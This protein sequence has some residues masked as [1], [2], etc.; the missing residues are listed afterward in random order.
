M[1]TIEVNDLKKQFVSKKGKLFRR[2][3]ET[4]KAVDGVSFSIKQGEIFSLLGPN[5]AGKTTTILMLLGLTEPTSGSAR[6]LALSA[7]NL[8]EIMAGYGPLV[9]KLLHFFVL[10]LCGKLRE[11]AR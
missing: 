2:S 5:G 11:R 3:K 10:G 6:V 8:R 9:A 7:S 1:N 4:I